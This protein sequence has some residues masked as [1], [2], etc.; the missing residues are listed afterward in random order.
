MTSP[1]PP[2]SALNGRR[3]YI[4]EDDAALRR[5]MSRM[6]ADS[7]SCIDEYES[8]ED[9]LGGYSERPRGCVLLDVKLPKMNGLE[10]LERTSELAPTNPVIMVSGYG[11][12]PSAVRAVQMGALDFL[13]K[14]FRKEQLIEV[15]DRAFLQIESN[16][17]AELELE[18]LTPRER[19]VLIAFADGAPNKI[20]AARLSLS[21]RTVEMHRARIFRKLGVTNLSQAL[22]RARDSGLT[23]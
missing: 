15:V 22:L 4:V 9:F 17:Q 6:L 19:D 18:C 12:I 11:D 7:V 16:A 10:L 3:V 5:M 20:V 14:P 1:N 8:A 2:G 23:S 13:Q 21:P